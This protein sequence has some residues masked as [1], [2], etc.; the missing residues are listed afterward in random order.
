MR[1][2]YYI[3]RTKILDGQ[4]IP[5]IPEFRRGQWE[6]QEF[7]V[8]LRYILSWSLASLGFMSPPA[9]ASPSLLPKK[10]EEVM[11]ND[12]KGRELCLVCQRP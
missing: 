5:V 11:G 7:K 6:D 9:P 2:V 8:T 1:F 4:T 12:V 10:R 3:E